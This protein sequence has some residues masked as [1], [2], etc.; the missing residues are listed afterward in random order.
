MSESFE[1]YFIPKQKTNQ[2]KKEKPNIKNQKDGKREK[3]KRLVCCS[4]TTHVFKFN[5]FRFP[6]NL[7]VSVYSLDIAQFYTWSVPAPQ[8]DCLQNIFWWRLVKLR[9]MSSTS[10]H[11]TLQPMVLNYSKH[12]QC[13]W[14]TVEPVDQ[15]IESGVTSTEASAIR[16]D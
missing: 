9:Q 15:F 11:S 6:K 3:V 8:S 12:D 1:N 4:K 16:H 2:I 5:W 7:L 13:F 10:C 14:S